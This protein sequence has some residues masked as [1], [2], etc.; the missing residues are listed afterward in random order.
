MNY[1]EKAIGELSLSLKYEKELK[2]RIK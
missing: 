1:R 2:E